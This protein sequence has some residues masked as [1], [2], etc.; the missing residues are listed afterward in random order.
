M[1]KVLGITPLRSHG[2]PRSP[3]G[4]TEHVHA[5]APLTATCGSCWEDGT[6]AGKA[7][8]YS[9]ADGR[10]REPSGW[11]ARQE[12]TA[13]TPV[14]GNRCHTEA[15]SAGHTREPQTVFSLYSL[16]PR[17]L[18][19]ESNRCSNTNADDINMCV[20]LKTMLSRAV[21]FLAI[22]SL[23]FN[24]ISVLAKTNP[25]GPKEPCRSYAF[26]YVP[27]PWL[28]PHLTPPTKQWEFSLG[29]ETGQRSPLR[30]G[31]VPLACLPL[32]PEQNRAL[33]FMYLTS[34]SVF[35]SSSWI[36]SLWNVLNC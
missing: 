35:F 33:T 21:R 4:R 15:V 10:W 8:S 22:F 30:A 17:V 13:G 18:V 24:K 1:W 2:W 32:E 25:L 29:S 3:P 20:L 14:T 9:T 7:N 6:L 34:S 11:R 19:C 28:R 23:C 5:G 12:K 31:P 36:I 16:R 27:N 26:M